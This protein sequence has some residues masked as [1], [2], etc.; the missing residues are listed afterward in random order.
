MLDQVLGDFRLFFARSE[1]FRGQGGAPGE[2]GGYWPSFLGPEAWSLDRAGCIRDLPLCCACRLL[3]ALTWEGRRNTRSDSNP[4]FEP[5]ALSPQAVPLQQA[6]AL[7]DGSLSPH[8]SLSPTYL[9]LVHP[10]L[11]GRDPPSCAYPPSV[12]AWEGAVPWVWAGIPGRAGS[13]R[14]FL[15][16]Q[17]S[18]TE[19]EGERGRGRKGGG[20]EGRRKQAETCGQSI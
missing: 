3:K 1:G 11:L 5:V 9:C 7:P 16:G 2:P 8:L 17:V 20:E 19:S 6:C 10:L 13:G 18:D 15:V 12:T 4:L 14:D